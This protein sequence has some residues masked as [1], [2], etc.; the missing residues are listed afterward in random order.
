MVSVLESVINRGLAGHRRAHPQGAHLS[1]PDQGL[2]GARVALHRVRPLMGTVRVLYVGDIVG[3]PGRK[4]VFR[5]VDRI[6]QEREV[7]LAIGNAENA[8]GG[9]GVTCLSLRLMYIGSR[10]I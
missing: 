2:P 8:A 10:P 4:A 7:D 9:F 1:G 5:H 6:R 3:E